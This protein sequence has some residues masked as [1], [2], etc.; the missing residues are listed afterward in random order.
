ML[1]KGLVLQQGRKGIG[2]TP[3]D[4]KSDLNSK[5]KR[6]KIDGTVSEL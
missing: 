4:R 1:E 2:K 6:R 5:D 3:T